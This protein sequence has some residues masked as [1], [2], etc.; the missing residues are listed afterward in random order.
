MRGLHPSKPNILHVIASRI[1]D[2]R[3]RKGNILTQGRPVGCE[4]ERHNYDDHLLNGVEIPPL[5]PQGVADSAVVVVKLSTEENTVTCLRIKLI[6]RDRKIKGKGPDMIT[7]CASDAWTTIL[8]RLEQRP[9][10]TECSVELRRSG[11]ADE[12]ECKRSEMR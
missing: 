12:R 8:R 6:E 11:G 10:E 9:K 7:K 5:R 4:P 2:R 3:A 1:G